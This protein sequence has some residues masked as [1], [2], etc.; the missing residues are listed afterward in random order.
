M[1][2]KEKLFNILN[3]K[4]EKNF[5]KKAFFTFVIFSY[6]TPTALGFVIFLQIGLI[7]PE[8]DQ[9]ALNSTIETAA[10]NLAE[11]YTSIMFRM[12][13]IGQNI[14][15][16]SP[17]YA[18]VCFYGISSIII[19]TYIAF[20]VLMFQLIKYIIYLL[21]N[22]RKWKICRLIVKN[23]EKQKNKEKIDWEN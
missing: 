1:K 10:T 6:L 15:K 22:I 8:L 5:W 17:F 3:P 19:S 9:V 14:A 20:G 12:V 23:I 11:S 13:D 4:R 2:L 21:L 18:K 16:E 7:T